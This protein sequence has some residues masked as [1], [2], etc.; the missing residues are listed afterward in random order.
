[1]RVRLGLGI[2]AACVLMACEA[3]PDASSGSPGVDDD[4]SEE[5][6]DDAAP[7][8][9]SSAMVGC[10]WAAVGR[11]MDRYTRLCQ[12]WGYDQGAF[13]YSGCSL[14]LDHCLHW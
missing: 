8:T 11:K 1:M 12:S 13:S 2:L 10:D 14:T 7:G 6:S 4:S 5:T 9:V 3:G